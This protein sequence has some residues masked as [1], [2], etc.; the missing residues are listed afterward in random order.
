MPTLRFIQL[1]D[2][3]LFDRA[4][5]TLRGMDTAQSLAAVVAAVRAR[6]EHIDGILATGDISHDGGTPSYRRFVQ[7]LAPLNAPIYCLPGNHDALGVFGC[8]L[9]GAR[10]QSGGRLLA[11]DW[12]LIFLDS[13]VPG[14]VHGHLRPAE[15]ARLDAAL[16][17]HPQ[18]HALICLHHQPVPVGTAWLDRLMLDNPGTLFEIIEKHPNVRALLWGHIHQD[19]DSMRNGVRLLASPST[20]IQFRPG[21]ADFTLDDRPPGYRWL[22]LHSD[23][24]I[25]TGLEYLTIT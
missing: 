23:G 12:Q 15:L 21:C 9:K 18:Q 19:F 1:T 8:A 25:D 16:R 11:G 13:A 3:H 24:R 2:T 6:H 14:A 5:G 20:C 22:E 17:E 4:D 7:L 10:V